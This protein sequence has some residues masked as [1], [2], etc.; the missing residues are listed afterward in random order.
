MRQSLTSS[1]DGAVKCM[2][3]TLNLYVT[4]VWWNP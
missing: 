3:Q 1:D 4:V 2:R